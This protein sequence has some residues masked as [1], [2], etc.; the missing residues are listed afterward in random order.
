MRPK[1]PAAW[2][3]VTASPTNPSHGWWFTVCF[4]NAEGVMITFLCN[5]REKAEALAC[6]ADAGEFHGLK[7]SPGFFP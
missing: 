7:V 4:T 1:R 3:G 5:S 2:I 6:K